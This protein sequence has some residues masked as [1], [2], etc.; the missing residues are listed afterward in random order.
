MGEYDDILTELKHG[1]DMMYESSYRTIIE[2]IRKGEWPSKAFE[3]EM[4]R[5]IKE[6]HLRP[7][8]VRRKLLDRLLG[9]YKSG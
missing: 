6:E 1:L 8:S 4:N 9:V 3:D 5:L 7:S 2:C